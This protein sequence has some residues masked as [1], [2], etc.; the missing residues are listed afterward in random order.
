MLSPGTCPDVDPALHE[1][2]LCDSSVFVVSVEVVVLFLF[3]AICFVAPTVATKLF[4]W[5][6]A[7]PV[8]V[9][10]RPATASLWFFASRS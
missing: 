9:F 4:R 10:K 1:Y 6:P 5:F 8:V 7:M 3:K 2:P